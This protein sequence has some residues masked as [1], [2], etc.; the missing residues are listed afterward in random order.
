MTTAVPPTAALDPRVRLAAYWT[1]VMFVMVYV[2]LFSLY[3]SDVRAALESGTLNGF[4]LT[5]AFL[6]GTTAYVLPGILMI[7]ASVLLAGRAARWLTLVVAAGYAVTI[8]A[9]AVGEQPY[10]LLG[11]AVELGLL[12]VI[13]RTAWSLGR[14]N[15]VEPGELLHAG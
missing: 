11:S 10:Y 15:S 1:A 5:P 12:A 9:A 8:V 2:D 4:A 6:A 13:A 7:A 14:R 3:R